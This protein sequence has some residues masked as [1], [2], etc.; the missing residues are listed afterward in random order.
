MLQFGAVLEVD[1]HA[2]V[3]RR[4]AGL[5]EFRIMMGGD[6]ADQLPHIVAIDALRS[7]LLHHRRAVDDR[8]RDCVTHVH[9]RRDRRQRSLQWP[10]AVM[11][12]GVRHVDV[13]AVDLLTLDRPFRHDVEDRVEW[14]MK[15]AH[16]GVG[17]YGNPQR[18]P[19]LAQLVGDL[20]D[21]R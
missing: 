6:L 18:L 2:G 21:V 1:G 17:F 12:G 16:C 7:E 5:V 3:A 4:A 9:L 19:A 8:G 10:P 14:R 20:A 11:I 13:D 15:S